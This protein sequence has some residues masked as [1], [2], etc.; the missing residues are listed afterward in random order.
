V[1][2]GKRHT[3]RRRVVITGLGTI[4]PLGN[5]VE[6]YWDNLITGKSGIRLAQKADLSNFHVK[7]AGE[8][9]PPDLSEYF[10]SKKM[11]KRLDPYILYSHIAGTQAVKDSGL[12]IDKE[13]HR[14][15][16]IIG[17]GDAG[18]KTQIENINRIYSTGMQSAS[19][20]YI[21]AAIPNTGTAYFSQEWNLQGPS[22]SVNSACATSNHAIGTSVLLIQSGMA[23]AMFA[24]GSEA[25]VNEAGIAAFGNIMALSDRND[26]PETASRP[27]DI[28]RN[29]F[30]L[31]EGAG[32]VCLEELEHARKRGAHI[33]AEI[34]GFNFT[35]DAHDLVA[36][37]PEARN[38]SAA[39]QGAI[40]SAGLN[41][42]DLDL[43]NCHGTSTY[44][45]DKIESLAIN[46]V[47]KEY[48]PKVKV[49]STKSM[50]GHLLG[51]ASVVEAIAAILAFER[52]II[53]PSTNLF[54]QDP[55][56]NLNVVTEAQ[57]DKNVRHIISNAFGFGGHNASIILSKCD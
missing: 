38:S 2:N 17:T 21:I 25:A 39:M 30:V 6:E 43:I 49:H 32:V 51:G 52:S 33:Y 4:N 42:E 3:D 28:D 5:T 54:E 15:G 44:M 36:P 22:F 14:Y 12:D 48:A 19:P 23:D 11:I 1:K 31:S 46:N 18:V 45:G 57:E 37:H 50:I 55:E 40:D 47:L 53:H 7:I 24:G 35:T 26:S 8:I 20:F 27:F 10:R 56:I 34:S 9:D 29:G 13:P 41:P 16:A